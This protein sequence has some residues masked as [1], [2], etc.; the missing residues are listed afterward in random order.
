MFVTSHAR[1]TFTHGV[2]IS[3]LAYGEEGCGVDGDDSGSVEPSVDGEGLFMRNSVYGVFELVEFD[4]AEEDN[5]IAFSDDSKDFV[6]DWG[7]EEGAEDGEAGVM[8]IWWVHRV[9]F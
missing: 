3:R 7:M 5:V 9:T 4:G 6:E 1:S 2:K 8:F